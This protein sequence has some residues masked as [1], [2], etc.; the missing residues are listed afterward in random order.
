MGKPPTLRFGSSSSKCKKK[1]TASPSW[2]KRAKRASR[3]KHVKNREGSAL[4]DVESAGPK[5]HK[6]LLKQFGSLRGVGGGERGSFETRTGDF[7]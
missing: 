4:D 5:K 7:G 1:P 6:D 2:A 3:A